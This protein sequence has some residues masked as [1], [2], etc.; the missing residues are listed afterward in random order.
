[1]ISYA[2]NREDVLLARV[3]HDVKAGFYV[4]VGANDPEHC[5]VTKHFYDLGWRGI[6]FEPGRVFEKLAAARPRDINL[7]VAAS[8]RALSAGSI[9][10]ARSISTSGA[11]DGTAEAAEVAMTSSRDTVDGVAANIPVHR[12][13]IQQDS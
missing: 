4:D 6:N 8:D 9:A 11:T 5:S 7:N 13:S 12:L 1:M 3:F 2:Q 10:R